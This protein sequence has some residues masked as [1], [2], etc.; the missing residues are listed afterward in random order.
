VLRY[1]GFTQGL[2]LVSGEGSH[3]LEATGGPTIFCCR[4]SDDLLSP[5]SNNERVCAETLCPFPLLPQVV[6]KSAL[7][8]FKNSLT[9][10]KVCSLIDLS[11]GYSTNY[12]AAKNRFI[13]ASAEDIC[14][15]EQINF[16]LTELTIHMEVRRELATFLAKLPE[17]GVRY[18]VDKTR[19]ARGE[20]RDLGLPQA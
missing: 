17:L 5:F 11:Q 1:S 9:L 7:L 6:D 2:L 13:M 20:D 16:V 14:L 4:V 8:L 10:N 3:S 15:C 19:R 18:E 12:L